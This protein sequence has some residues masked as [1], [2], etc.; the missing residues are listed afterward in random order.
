MAE[1]GLREQRGRGDRR[2]AAVALA[3]S[4]AAALVVGGTAVPAQADPAEH[5]VALG[6]SYTSG[7]RIPTQVDVACERSDQNYPSLTA[8]ALGVATFEDASCGGARTTHMWE[9]QGANPPQLDAIDKKTTLVTVGISG[10]DIG[11]GE[12]IGT[13]TVLSFTDPTGNPCQRQYTA[14]GEDVLA[15]RIADARTKV[16]AVLDAIHERSPRARVVVVGYPVIVPDD[17]VGCWPAVQMA[18]GDIPYLRDTEKRLNAML[19]DA[20]A[21]NRA[22]YTDTYASTVGHDIC[23][24][25]ADRWVEPLVP[26]SPAG[27]FHPNAKGEAAMADAVVATLAKPGRGRF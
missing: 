1:Q 6:D 13:C 7:P 9:A 26:A 16:D 17:G 3:V 2:R 10:N 11:F 14:T 19:A 24:S 23:K 20:A 22:A 4:G 18:A 5:Y 12:I 25:P 15:T 8:K 27:S 21:H